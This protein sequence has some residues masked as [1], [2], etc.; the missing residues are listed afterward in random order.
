M[1]QHKRGTGR[2]QSS[3]LPASIEDYVHSHALVRVIE[4]YVSALDMAGLGFARSRPADTGRPGYAPE[5]LLGLYLYGYWNRVRSS[6]GLEAECKRNLELMWLMCELAPDHKT[7]AEFRR[8]NAKAF[9]QACVQFVQFLREAE[10]VGGELPTVAV[11]GSKFKANASKKSVVDAEQAGKERAKIRRRIEEYLKQMDEADAAEEAEVEPTKEQIERAIERLRKR[12]RKLEQ[13]QA[14]F[15]ERPNTSAT[16]RAG[17]TDADCVLLKQGAHEALAGYN[18]QQAVDTQH[19]LIVAHEV[20]TQANDQRG[21]Q[22]TASQAQEALEAAAMVVLADTGFMNGQQAQA[23]EDQGITPVVPMQQPSNSADG[24]L[25]AKTMFVYDA[26]TDTYRCPA[27]ALLKRFGRYKKRQTDYYTTRACASCAL[28]SQCTHGKR[29]RISR[30]WYAAPAERA[31][32]RS[33][34]QP[35]LMRLRSASVEHPFGTLKAILSGGFLVRTL[36]KVKGE[37]ALAV[38]TYNLK[39]TLNLLG[40]ERLMQKLKASPVLNGA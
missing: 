22:P 29:R 40:I 35:E 19:H 37:M 25:F 13:A 28:K 10:L 12:D 39:R 21:L 7:I 15:A 36:S 23:C 6:R 24:Q 8:V 34:A 14:K 11:D 18:V 16:P 5:D 20:T 26:Q 27:G 9:Q 3:L 1:S 4:A 30:S 38:L 17:L 32:H 33:R 2:T 31:H